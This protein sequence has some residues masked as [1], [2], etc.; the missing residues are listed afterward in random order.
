M[1]SNNNN[2][3]NNNSEGGHGVNVAEYLGV[4]EDHPMAQFFNDNESDLRSEVVL[5]AGV[6]GAGKIRTT[7]KHL[8]SLLGGDTNWNKLL[9]V[10]T[11]PSIY[12]SLGL[13]ALDSAASMSHLK[14]LLTDAPA[15]P[16]P[17]KPLALYAFEIRLD[18]LDEKLHSFVPSG[19]FDYVGV[20]RTKSICVHLPDEYGRR[21]T[22]AFRELKKATYAD[23]VEE[24]L[25]VDISIRVF[26]RSTLK[27]ATLAETEMMVTTTKMSFPGGSFPLVS[28]I[29]VHPVIYNHSH[30]CHD[31]DDDDDED[32]SQR[33]PIFYTKTVVQFL[34]GG[35]PCLGIIFVGTR[36]QDEENST[37]ILGLMERLEWK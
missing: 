27:F 32:P 37:Q 3:N 10:H 29:D 20:N 18:I 15:A 22:D 16:R 17:P 35:Q 36:L 24:L 21:L 34:G 13:G 33:R 5:F 28:A 12:Q 7:A 2:N 14:R 31:A 6:Q 4:P 11:L 30:Y 8:W 26:D 9:A 23:E 1:D 19:F 25:E